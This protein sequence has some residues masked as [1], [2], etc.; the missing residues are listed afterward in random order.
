MQRSGGGQGG[1]RIAV[2]RVAS[3]ANGTN[4]DYSDLIII[5]TIPQESEDVTKPSASCKNHPL[6]HGLPDHGQPRPAT[7]PCVL[8]AA[9]SADAL[10]TG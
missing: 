7:Q 8:S 5:Y 2:E 10:Q 4:H 9:L 1:R 6:T 3:G